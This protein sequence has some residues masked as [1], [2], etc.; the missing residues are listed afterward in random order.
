MKE[1]ENPEEEEANFHPHD[2]G[3]QEAEEA[4]KFA[5]DRWDMKMKTC[6]LYTYIY[7]YLTCRKNR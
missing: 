1:N 2:S 6:K 4:I 7:I 5:R 3:D